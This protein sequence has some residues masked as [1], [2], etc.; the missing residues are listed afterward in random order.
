[1]PVFS[2]DA[3]YPAG[4]VSSAPIWIIA[5]YANES[6]MCYAMLICVCNLVLIFTWGC[7]AYPLDSMNCLLVLF[8]FYVTSFD[9]EALF[10]TY[11]LVILPLNLFASAV[12]ENKK[13]SEKL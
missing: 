4:C 2:G 10:T 5:L 8:N 3:S 9:N 11:P 6:N 7:I 1:M 13:C 12:N